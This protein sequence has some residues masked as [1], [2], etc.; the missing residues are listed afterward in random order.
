MENSVFNLYQE[1][2]APDHV[3]QLCYLRRPVSRKMRFEQTNIEDE[4]VLPRPEVNLASLLPPTDFSLDDLFEIK[5][6]EL[7]LDKSNAASSSRISIEEIRESARRHISKPQHTLAEEVQQWFALLESDW[8]QIYR[9]IPCDQDDSVTTVTAAAVIPDIADVFWMLEHC[10][11]DAYISFVWNHLLISLLQQGVRSNTLD[12]QRLMALLVAHHS[13]KSLAPKDFRAKVRARNFRQIGDALALAHSAFARANEFKTLDMERAGGNLSHEFGKIGFASKGIPTKGKFKLSFSKDLLPLKAKKQLNQEAKPKAKFVTS[14]GVAMAI[15]KKKLVQEGTTKSKTNGFA[16]SS[17]MRQP[18]KDRLPKKSLGFS[19]MRFQPKPS[20]P[21]NPTCTSPKATQSALA[22]AKPLLGRLAIN[23]VKK[24]KYN[25]TVDTAMKKGKFNNFQPQQKG[26]LPFAARSGTE[27][28]NLKKRKASQDKNCSFP[29]KSAR[30]YTCLALSDTICDKEKSSVTTARANAKMTGDTCSDIQSGGLKTKLNCG[31]LLKK[32]SLLATSTVAAPGT[33]RSKAPVGM[34]SAAITASCISKESRETVNEEVKAKKPLVDG[35]DANAD[36][37]PTAHDFEQISVY[38]A[39]DGHV[40]AEL[41]AVPSESREECG[42]DEELAIIMM[43][44]MDDDKE[45]EFMIKAGAL[46]E[47]TNRMGLEQRFLRKRLL[48]V[49]ADVSESLLDALTDLM[50]EEGG[51][52]IDK[53][54]FDI[55]VDVDS[56]DAFPHEDRNQVF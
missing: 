51:I 5:A 50:V 45:E 15:N 23:A 47:T 30:G 39:T 52:G 53:I 41:N 42:A 24:K 48:D 29:S 26:L 2:L 7:S 44:T 34:P 8:I 37:A 9:G 13:F 11:S 43:C 36:Q 55:H 56:G 14:S 38:T 46:Q 40:R 35:Y 18:A 27:S 33:K 16:T 12:H 31:S 10:P 19:F 54:N 6:A 25:S 22:E 1:G 17:F 21:A 20:G 3:L 4:F 28:F 49:H 32:R